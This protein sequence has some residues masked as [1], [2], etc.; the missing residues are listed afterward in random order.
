MRLDKA[1]FG[2]LDEEDKSSQ[3]ADFPVQ[4]PLEGA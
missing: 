4:N 3:Q 2:L 1:Q